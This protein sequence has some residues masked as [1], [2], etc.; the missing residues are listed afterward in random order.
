MAAEREAAEVDLATSDASRRGRASLCLDPECRRC[1]L[2]PAHGGRRGRDGPSSGR[3]SKEGGHIIELKRAWTA[4][5]V[6]A[7]LE[8]VRIH[9]LRHSFAS[10]GV[11]LGLGLPMI[12]ALLGHR[13]VRTTAR[14]AHLDNDPQQRASEAIA[15]AIKAM[16]S[17]EP[18]DVVP[19]PNRAS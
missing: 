1:R 15:E 4:V 16:M 6:K 8:D 18:A 7:E 14:Y 9:D 3:V 11:G 12:G 5:C 2:Q 19:F 17:G 10:V 13:E